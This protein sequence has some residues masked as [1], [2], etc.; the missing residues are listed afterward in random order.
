MGT[1][2]SADRAVD[3]VRSVATNFGDDAVN[4]ITDRGLPRWIIGAFALVSLVL[5]AGYARV[6]VRVWPVWRAGTGDGYLDQHQLLVLGGI[7]GILLALSMPLLVLHSRA[8]QWRSEWRWALRAA[9]LALVVGAM[10]LMNRQD[11]LLD[12]E[13]RHAA[14]ARTG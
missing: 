7:T 12:E 9:W 14:S 6:L 4:D 5:V 10:V 11:R 13:A 1:Q 3:F 2:R 8:G